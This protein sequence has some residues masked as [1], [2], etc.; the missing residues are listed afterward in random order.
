MCLQPRVL[1]IVDAVESIHRGLASSCVVAHGLLPA[2][3]DSATEA[4]RVIATGE[5]DL[6]VVMPPLGH[7]DA[8]A[9]VAAARARC[10]NLPGA[11]V[12]GESRVEYTAPRILWTER[13]A[14]A[15]AIDAV[16]ALAAMRPP[17]ELLS[18]DE[19]TSELSDRSVE[20]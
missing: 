1:L 9:L 7:G 19:T 12:L 17:A 14:D 20:P 11:I 4:L 10:P 16:L 13:P 3:A 8:F 18:W 15:A 6:L 2:F 5:I